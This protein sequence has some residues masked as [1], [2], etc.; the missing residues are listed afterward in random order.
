[1][2]S[3]YLPVMEFLRTSF[4]VVKFL[5]LSLFAG[6]FMEVLTSDPWITDLFAL[7]QRT[8]RPQV[9]DLFESHREAID[10]FATLWKTL[11]FPYALNPRELS[12]LSKF[13]SFNESDEAWSNQLKIR[14]LL[15]QS[16]DFPL[17]DPDAL[18][19]LHGNEPL[20]PFLL[21]FLLGDFRLEV[22]FQLEQL[23]RRVI[24]TFQEDFENK[25]GFINEVNW[26]INYSNSLVNDWQDITID[27]SSTSDLFFYTLQ[28]NIS[29]IF[30]E[31]KVEDINRA[32]DLVKKIAIL[33]GIQLNRS[34]GKK[35]YS[36]ELQGN[37]N[38]EDS[39][40]LDMVA[41]HKELE[42]DLKRREPIENNLGKL[43][44]IIEILKNELQQGPTF[45]PTESILQS[46]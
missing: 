16:K 17:N 37:L 3:L 11:L 13:I 1:M 24:V 21:P 18:L 42:I 25:P 29:Y 10:S 40:L 15:L 31:K 20:L 8:L 19:S 36:Q 26:I 43:L 14:D 9:Q 22:L 12:L 38:K 44:A 32:I 30:Y 46:A 34:L 35:Y 41:V 4:I 7:G 39:L 2:I 28:Q 45:I 6:A 23:K 27:S 5:T 33:S